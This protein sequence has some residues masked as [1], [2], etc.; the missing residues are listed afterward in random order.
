[1]TIA[2]S[3]N[4]LIDN[5]LALA[6]MRRAVGD[7]AFATLSRDRR[8]AIARLARGAAPSIALALMPEITAC[9][10]LDEPDPFTP[11]T[12]PTATSN[13]PNTPAT[14]LTSLTSVT[15]VTSVTSDTSDTS[16]TPPADL[17]ITF[18]LRDNCMADPVV[19]RLLI[20]HAFTAFI[21]S[22]IY[23]RDNATTSALHADD[24]AATLHRITR[25]V[26]AANPPTRLRPYPA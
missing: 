2:L 13:T 9:N 21:L 15:S 12:P 8:P 25:T 10:L 26:S 17:L 5:I 18:T 3:L 23:S 20:E 7:T 11:P 14:S 1:M 16:V 22:E 6:A 4:A 24:Y 19:L